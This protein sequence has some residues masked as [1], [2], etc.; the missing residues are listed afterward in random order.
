MLS[1]KQIVIAVGILALAIVG[2]LV[3]HAYIG[4]RESAAQLEQVR[5]DVSDVNAKAEAVRV[6]AE[7]DRADAEKRDA[8]RAQQLL[9]TLAAIATQKQQPVSV[10]E[11]AAR[12]TARIPGSGVTPTALDSLPNAPSAQK[13]ISDY[14]YDCDSCKVERDSLRQASVNKDVQISDLKT[15]NTQLATQKAGVEKE[16][17]AAVTAA[18]GG[19]FWHR[20]KS[21]TK[22]MVIGIGTGIVVDLAARRH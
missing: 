7:K 13:A 20:L 3:L 2:G 9:S 14:V 22:W 15:E 8:D 19:T 21:N 11:L 12:I 1:T 17:D 18:K 5:K 10:D 4:S 6:S 16:R